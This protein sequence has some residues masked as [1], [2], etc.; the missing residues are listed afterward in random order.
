MFMS[1]FGVKCVYLCSDY[2]CHVSSGCGQSTA[3]ASIYPGCV[4]YRQRSQ[5]V[6]L[7]SGYW[8]STIPSS[9]VT[10]AHVKNEFHFRA[11]GDL[12]S[13]AN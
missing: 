2:S 8:Y 7:S 1:A 13:N 12:I 6:A 9:H 11:A 3:G 5:L 4:W 10:C